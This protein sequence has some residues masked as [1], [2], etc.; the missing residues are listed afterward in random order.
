MTPITT[1]WIF[2]FLIDLS[3]QLSDGLQ[4]NVVQTFTVPRQLLMILS[5]STNRLDFSLILWNLL[6]Y[7]G[8]TATKF[9]SKVHSAQLL[10]PCDFDDYL[11]WR[12]LKPPWHLWFS[13]IYLSNVGWNA[14]NSGADIHG[15]QKVNLTNFGDPRRLMVP[16]WCILMT[17]MILRF[18]L[19]YFI[20][21]NFVQ[22]FMV[23]RWCIIFLVAL[24]WWLFKHWHLSYAPVQQVRKTKWTLCM[25]GLVPVDNNH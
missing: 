1:K 19:N 14:M 7:I 22:M 15:S 5:S 2:V 21:K 18:S 25:F 6:I 17:L 10:Y 12:L 3:Q 23:A 16:R 20:N 8:W 24:T 11:T 13:L 4:W 9:G